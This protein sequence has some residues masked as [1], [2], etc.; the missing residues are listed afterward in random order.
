[1]GLTANENGEDVFD[2]LMDY[3]IIVP[4]RSDKYPIENKFRINPCVKHTP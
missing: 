3:K 4:H 1:M 2:K